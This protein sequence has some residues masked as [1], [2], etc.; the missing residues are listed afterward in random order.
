M[1]K[2]VLKNGKEVKDVKGRVIKAK[3]N[4]AIY[5]IIES[6]NRGKHERV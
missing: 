1:V 5:T 4:K 2:H 3:D 6:M